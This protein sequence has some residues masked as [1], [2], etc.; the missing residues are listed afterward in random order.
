MSRKRFP[1]VT[2]AL[3]NA[4]VVS[5]G[6][7]CYRRNWKHWLSLSGKIPVQGVH[8]PFGVTRWQKHSL[9]CNRRCSALPW[10]LGMW[11]FLRWCDWS[12]STLCR[13]IGFLRGACFGVMQ[14]VTNFLHEIIQHGNDN[15]QQCHKTTGSSKTSF[16]NTKAKNKQKYNLTYKCWC[17][18]FLKTNFHMHTL[19]RWF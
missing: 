2:P 6:T 16:Q 4:H 14:R 17:F 1:W 8:F 18:S 13:I 12:I 7:L 11:N 9:C 15:S 3:R 5:T 10:L 19:I